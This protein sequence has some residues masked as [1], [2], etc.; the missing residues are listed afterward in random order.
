MLFSFWDW[1]GFCKI[2]PV[3]NEFPPSRLWRAGT[4]MK[5]NA[6]MLLLSP[7]IWKAP[8][9]FLSGK[10]LQRSALWGKGGA[11]RKMTWQ[12]C[13]LLCGLVNSKGSFPWAKLS[14]VPSA[15]H[16]RTLRLCVVLHPASTL[17]G[18]LVPSSGQAEMR[19]CFVRHVTSCFS[20]YHLSLYL[21][22]GK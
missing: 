10:L 22:S 7:Q 6:F 18:C 17:W 9:S 3:W 16:S 5:E 15:W 19:L 12:P 14:T 2:I 4:M 21:R 20:P 11:W 1:P 13:W 8:C